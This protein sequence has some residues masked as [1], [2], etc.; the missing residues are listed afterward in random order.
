M[1]E[2]K[3]SYFGLVGV[4]ALAM[5]TE[6]NE[7]VSEQSLPDVMGGLG[8]SHDP[9][10]W[11]NSLYISAEVIGMSLGPWLGITFT[12]RRFSVFVAHL[13]MISAALIPLTQNLTLLYGLRI[14][15]GLAGGFAVPLLMTIA[16]RVL[17]PPIRLY[18][19]AAYALTATFFPN[20]SASLSGLWTDL[21]DWRFV[22]WQAVPLCSMAA[23]MLWY[24]IPSEA[25]KYARFKIFD[26]RGA[27]L[28]LVGM[29]ALSTLLQQGDRFDWFNSPTICILALIGFG[30]VP[31]FV[32]NEWYHPLPLFKFQ[33]L[34]RRNF[35]YGATTLLIFVVIALSSS[36]LPADFLREVAGYR[37]EQAYL[38]TLEVACMQ[39]VMLPAMA[40]VLNQEWVDSRVVSLIGMTFMLAACI[41]DSFLTS[42]WNRNEFYLWQFCQG[43]GESMIVMPL[44][45]MSTNALVPA[46]GPFA[47]AMVNTPR[48]IAETIGIW[49]VQLIHRWRGSLH[50][51]RI[52]DQIGRN[53][54]RLYQ[55]NN[56][57][58]QHPA[59]LKPDGSL[60]SQDSLIEFKA[61]IAKQTAVLTLSDSFMVIA[62]IVVFLMVW[63]LVVPQR[64][65]PPRINFIQK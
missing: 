22:F 3:K 48:A 31:L 40:V 42:V 20:L 35:A 37:P 43:L 47:A 56:P 53:R 13:A 11:F 54:Y 26:W 60:R 25:P 62:A 32:I 33:L 50:S 18:G 29:G 39:L 55:A 41:G 12:L 21:V 51:D 52:T 65:Y 58:W 27:F 5:A 8:L 38:V 46:E 34:K 57:A 59:P 14:I 24:G 23:V 45:M 6:L 44:L 30:G 1:D 28:I 63:V 15:E 19:L 49:M 4:I 64:T 10:I 9:A 61:Q 2:R 17:D 7:Q 36:T 16:L